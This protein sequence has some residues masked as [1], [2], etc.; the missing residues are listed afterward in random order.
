MNMARTIPYHSYGVTRNS[1]ISLHQLAS[2]SN[3][4]SVNKKQMNGSQPVIPC[5]KGP[6]AFIL[7]MVTIQD[8]PPGLDRYF[9]PQEKLNRRKANELAVTILFASVSHLVKS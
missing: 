5:Q 3:Y 6:K 2:H 8:F 4:F 7:P 9:S 1:L